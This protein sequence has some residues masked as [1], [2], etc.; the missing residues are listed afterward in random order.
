[1]LGDLSSLLCLAHAYAHAHAH[2][3]AKAGPAS[4]VAKARLVKNPR[5][6]PPWVPE[7]GDSCLALIFK[8]RGAWSPALTG[9]RHF[10]SC[11][12]H[13]RGGSPCLQG[14]KLLAHGVPCPLW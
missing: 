5:A 3:L 10:L 14:R 12:L 9:S 4:V 13:A 2:A 11:L 7:L 6:E 1:M 8:G